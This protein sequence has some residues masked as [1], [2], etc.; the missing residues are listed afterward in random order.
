MELNVALYT[1][2]G[3]GSYIK[4]QGSFSDYYN[5]FGWWGELE[6]L[7]PLNG[8]MLLSTGEGSLQYPS[9]EDF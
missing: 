3:L 8:Y 4:N 6:F 5:G 7:E 2:N 9:N 1:I